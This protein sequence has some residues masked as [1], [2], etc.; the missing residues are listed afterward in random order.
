MPDIDDLVST[1]DI[2]QIAQ[3][4]TSAVN[5]WHRRYETFPQPYIERW[6]RMLWLRT[7]VMD[8]LESSKRAAET[9]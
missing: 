1:Q 8:W 6:G 3:V 5:N 2:G 9:Q 4:R 7:E